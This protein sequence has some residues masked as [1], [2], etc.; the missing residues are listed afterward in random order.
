ML[1]I[2]LLFFDKM[3]TPESTVNYSQTVSSVWIIRIKMR[4][5]YHKKTIVFV[6][7]LSSW[8]GSV[9]ILRGVILKNC[10]FLNRTNMDRR[11]EL[12][13]SISHG[14]AE[15]PAPSGKQCSGSGGGRGVSGGGECSVRERSGQKVQRSERLREEARSGTKTRQ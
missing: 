8:G 15:A 5:Y 2:I 10:T 4:I 6:V 11:G 13:L 14:A 7:F 12:D 1:C 3:K 9:L